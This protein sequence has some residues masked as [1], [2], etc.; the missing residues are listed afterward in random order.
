MF[1]NQNK[2]SVRT[3]V[4]VKPI[5]QSV[6]LGRESSVRFNREM[7]NS[8]MITATTQIHFRE[9]NNWILW[10]NE[11]TARLLL[12]EGLATGGLCALLDRRLD[13]LAVVNHHRFSNGLR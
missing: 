5:K 7:V 13:F 12:R 3:P 2:A 11:K 1:V 8:T 6:A 9:L 4:F 10:S